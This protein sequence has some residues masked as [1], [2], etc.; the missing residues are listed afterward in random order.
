VV[1]VVVVSGLKQEQD[2]GVIVQV[3][4]EMLEGMGVDVGEKR[5]ED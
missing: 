5:K 4:G 2:H 3:V 1:A